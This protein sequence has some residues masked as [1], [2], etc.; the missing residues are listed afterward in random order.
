MNSLIRD[1]CLRMDGGN[2]CFLEPPNLTQSELTFSFAMC[3]FHF[4]FSFIF[5]WKISPLG[6]VI[7][8]LY[9]GRP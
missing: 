8:V 1:G 9:K 6:L 4:E 2:C 5:T 3:N 7:W